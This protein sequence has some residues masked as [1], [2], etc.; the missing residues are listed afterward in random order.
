M[1]E[2]TGT[3]T[4]GIIETFSWKSDPWIFKNAFC[5]LILGTLSTAK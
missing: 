4:D 1:E 5:S 3:I 2:E